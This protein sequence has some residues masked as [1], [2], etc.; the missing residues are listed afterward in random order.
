[1]VIYNCRYAG[2]GALSLN[3]LKAGFNSFGIHVADEDVRIL[4]NACD[5]SGDGLLQVQFVEFNIC[6][7]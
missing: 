5:T 3:E 6:N 1:M 7:L 2:D 4:F